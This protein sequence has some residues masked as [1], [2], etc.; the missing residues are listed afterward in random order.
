MSYDAWGN[1]ISDSAPGFQP[2][3][4]AGGL[5]DR[6]LALVRFG[7]RDYDPE[8]GRW[9]GKDPLR[10]G[11][12]MNA[13]LYCG[14]E[15]IN[16]VDPDGT[17]EITA[18][19]AAVAGYFA[20]G[21]TAG[22][23]AAAVGGGALIGN[24]WGVLIVTAI[25]VPAI[26]LTTDNP[27]TGPDAPGTGGPVPASPYS[28]DSPDSPGPADV[29]G[30]LAKGGKQNVSDTGIMAQCRERMAN[31]TNKDPCKHL[32]D[33]LDEAKAAGDTAL[34]KKLHKEQKTQGCRHRGGS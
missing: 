16:W 34:A 14:G 2:F 31:S 9:I 30:N 8:T 17:D 20:S 3:G 10:L 21:G 28:P 12:G 5:Y 33:M 7:A 25:A 1:T 26:A 29:P 18:G 15:P 32:Q 27:N 6:D 24:L 19:I 23:G 11:A 4:F 22:G 13:Y